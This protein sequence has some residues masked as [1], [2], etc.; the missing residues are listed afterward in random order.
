MDDDMKTTNLN[1]SPQIESKV[2]YFFSPYGH[3]K[4]AAYYMKFGN[5]NNIT[6]EYKKSGNA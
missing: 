3:T 1:T 2:N 4:T 6:E 5:D